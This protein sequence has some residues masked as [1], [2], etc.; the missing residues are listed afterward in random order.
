MGK[1]LIIVSVVITF[2]TAGLG[3]MNKGKLTDMTTRAT[4]AEA[5]ATKTKASLKT[6]SDSLAA[7]K[8]DLD[9]AK[10][11][12]EQVASQLA[13]T[14]TD[15]DKA[16]KD[17]SDAQASVTTLTTDKTTLTASLEAVTKERDDLKANSG[18]NPA[19]TPNNDLMAQIEELKTLNT[20]LT[21]DAQG[22]R[23][24]LSKYRQEATVRAQKILIKG[25]EGR[26][27]A[28]NPAWNFVV[29]SL[30]D[31][32]GVSNNTELLV[33][34]GNQLVGKIRVTSVEPST[35]IADIVAN[36]V[37]RGTVI[38]P[39]DHVIYQAAQE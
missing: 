36:S 5:D 37:P 1:L 30:G 12:K 11:E 6:A 38:S 29:L 18:T 34:R 26:I 28:V 23:D 3:F 4:T 17:L 7:T 2:L 20:K 21:S 19:P 9:S 32:Q 33:K 31:K 35:S 13:S 10:A 25:T 15:L 16:K 39:G 14:T 27:L 24:E 22:L 8:K